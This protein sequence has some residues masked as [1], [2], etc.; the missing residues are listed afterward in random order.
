MV[1]SSSRTGWL[2]GVLLGV[3]GSLLVL[4]PVRFMVLAQVR[5]ALSSR[6]LPF[7]NQFSGGP[8]EQEIALF[9]RAA[10]A[11]P[12][13]YLL[14]VGRATALAASGGLDRKSVHTT[15]TPQDNTLYRL[16]VVMRTFP[17]APGAYAHLARYMM[18]DR[19]R[20]D[21][22]ST[23][24]S[25]DPSKTSSKTDDKRPDADDLSVMEWA[26]RAGE[27]RD[28]DN[29]FWPTMLAVTCFAAHRDIDGMVALSRA[30]HKLRWDAYIYEE[31]LGE[32][33]LYSAVYGDYG[34]VQKIGPLSLVSFPHLGEIRQMA[35]LV[36]HI[37]EGDV[38]KGDVAHCVKLRRELLTLGM[39][40]RDRSQWAYEAL[41]GTDVCIISGT[42][43]SS[44]L[45]PA[46]IRTPA[47]WKQNGSS[48]LSL[49]QRTHRNFDIAFVSRE[50]DTSCTLRN[51]ID[52]ARFDRSFPGIPPGIPLAD[53]FGNWM[54]GVCIIQQIVAFSLMSVI[55]V[56]WQRW[57]L[58]GS[59][60]KAAAQAG[61]ILL[62]S[63]I[64]TTGFLMFT[65]GPSI[66]VA[67]IFLCLL[68]LLSVGL[69]NRF[70]TKR[71]LQ[72][73]TAP[74]E[75][76]AEER[77]QLSNRYCTLA[78]VAA[79]VPVIEIIFACRDYLSAQH[80]VAAALT[81]LVDVAHNLSLRETFIHALM[82]CAVPLLAMIGLLAACIIKRKT[83]LATSARG[84]LTMAPA[85]IMMLGLA[86]VVLLNR[87]LMLD[88][89][90]SRA[91]SEAAKNDLQW[92]LT[93]SEPSTDAAP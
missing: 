76:G 2:V 38:A 6:A 20:I 61:W 84:M 52:M 75:G 15:S 46:R 5:F 53:L 37:A 44:P 47:Q 80:P 11:H 28:S 83:A 34:A 33:R 32:W 13:D 49:L 56:L 35:Q 39:I 55:L 90:A 43:S 72:G 65:G 16:G 85:T 74:T 24:V 36:R 62:L 7:V 8:G 66:G 22:K 14:Q 12:D 1:T 42:D 4:P 57:S 50:I 21:P 79:A 41:I 31:V 10:A 88:T 64:C 23:P 69:I 87:T 77:N 60:V 18:N 81:S 9:D 63:G 40:M 17:D 25:A 19:I 73:D 29:A 93:H 51:R 3:C 27:K 30:A 71:G 78:A 26:L 59:R 68:A 86:Y 92:V 70:Q 58:F 89:E 82:A 45:V 91:I 67:T 48:Y 54:A